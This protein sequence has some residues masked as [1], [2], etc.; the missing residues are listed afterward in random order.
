MNKW[1]IDTAVLLIFFV[2]EDTFRKVFESVKKARPRILLLWQDGPRAGREDDLENIQKCR[3]VLDE[4][5]WECEVHTKFNTQNYGCDPSTFYAHQWAFSIVDKCIVLEDD[6][7]PCQSFFTYC[8]ELLDKY[9]ND[10][11]VSHICGH[12]FLGEAEWCPYDYLFAY[13]GTGA[14]ASWRR[15][16]ERWDPQYSYLDDEYAMNNIR[17]HYGKQSDYWLSYSGRHRKSGIPH[18]ES[19]LGMSE[20]LYSSYAIIPKKNLVQNIGVGQNATHST[21]DNLDIMPKKDRRFY[22]KAREIGPELKHP[23]YILPDA[24]YTKRMKK[25]AHPGFIKRIFNTAELVINLF[26]Y[27]RID[28]LKNALKKRLKIAK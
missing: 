27:G 22:G 1:E 12:N 13:T 3:A 25:Q 24:E 2:R 20:H 5:D 16:A 7:M 11:R 18:W 17:F 8:K 14:W 6:Q 4:I 26:R 21:V 28:I 9:E 15:T 19:I 10:P 23:R